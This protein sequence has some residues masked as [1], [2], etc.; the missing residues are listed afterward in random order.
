MEPRDLGADVED[1]TSHRTAADEGPGEA[2]A[3]MEPTGGQM[4]RARKPE[5]ELQWAWKPPWK[6][7]QAL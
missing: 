3:A 6:L 4:Q 5:E 7:H 1:E 2:V